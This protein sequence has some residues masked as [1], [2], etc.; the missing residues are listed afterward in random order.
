MKL[1]TVLSLSALAA[2]SHAAL[3]DVSETNVT[4]NART[5]IAPNQT[6]GVALKIFGA[7]VRMGDETNPGNNV[8]EVYDG[9]GSLMIKSSYWHLL[10]VG[11]PETNFEVLQGGMTK[12]YPEA[13]CG[14]TALTVF[15]D[16]DGIAPIQRWNLWEGPA[17]AEITRD[18]GIALSAGTLLHS[19]SVPWMF[20]LNP[21]DVYF[22][23]SNGVMHLISKNPSGQVTTNRL[24]VCP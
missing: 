6:N 8:L 13:S 15:G 4:I 1:I 10:W 7:H 23:N 9:F 3:F 18:G 5:V 11:Y 20:E 24:L 2:A 21:G 16:S 17:V 22:W 14:C 12:I 19:N